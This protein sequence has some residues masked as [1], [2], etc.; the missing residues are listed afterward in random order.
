MFFHIQV[1]QNSMRQQRRPKTLLIL[2]FLNFDFD[3]YCII[4]TE[5]GQSRPKNGEL[6]PTSYTL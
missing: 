6:T 4:E 5:E 3:G 1:Y 2:T